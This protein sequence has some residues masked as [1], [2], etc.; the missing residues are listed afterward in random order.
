MANHL[1][2]LV[3]SIIQCVDSNVAILPSAFVMKPTYSILA[4][5]MQKNVWSRHPGILLQ[6]LGA[7]NSVLIKEAIDVQHDHMHNGQRR[8]MR[9]VKKQVTGRRGR[10]CMYRF[11]N[12]SYSGSGRMSLNGLDNRL[13][14]VAVE[15]LSSR[16]TRQHVS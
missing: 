9:K 6:N 4:S 7:R 11:E 8:C 2:P 3:I 1:A 5:T 15:M 16:K 10:P 12:R 13:F 14:V